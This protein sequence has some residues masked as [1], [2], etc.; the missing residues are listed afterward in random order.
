M[1][2]LFNNVG[3]FIRR[4]F[5]FLIIQGL[6]RHS[7]RMLFVTSLYYKL[8]DADTVSKDSLEQLNKALRVAD[9]VDSME[10]PA[11]IHNWIWDEELIGC[12]Y[13]TID[14]HKDSLSF[15]KESLEDLLKVIP[16]WLWYGRQDD[17]LDDINLLLSN[18]YGVKTGGTLAS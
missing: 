2:T 17:M 5:L 14:L 15:T 1:S 18:T 11:I 7:K 6:S 9:D 4:I 13:K 12:F 16:Q 8:I 10:F 3:R